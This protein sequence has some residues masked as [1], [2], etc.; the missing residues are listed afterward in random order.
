MAETLKDYL[1]GV[2]FETKGADQAN[3]AVS[4]LDG[5]IQQ[6]GT[7]LM[8]AAEAFRGLIGQM[9]GGKGTVEE[10]AKSMEKGSESAGQMKE[11]LREVNKQGKLSNLKQGKHNVHELELAMKKASG[12]IKK[13]AKMAVG[14]LVGSNILTAFKNVMEFNENLAKS[15]KELKK[16]VEQTRAYNLALQVM[17][18]TA[19]EIEKDKSLKATFENLQKIGNSLALPEAA[20]GIRNIGAVKDSLMELKMVGSYAIQWIYYKVQELAAGPL[21]ETRKLLGGMRDWLSGNIK[22]IAEGIGKAFGWVVQIINSVAIAIGKVLGWI[23]K[24]PPAI[25]IAGAAAIAVIMAVKS[26][27]ALITMII[28]A[29]LLLIDDFVT[30]MEGGESLF[31]DFWGACIEWIKKIQP[32]IDAVSGWI[33]GLLNNI[34]EI[35]SA[36]GESVGEFWQT[37]QDNGT[38]A[39][40]QHV[41]ENVFSIIQGLVDTAVRYFSDLFLGI[42]NGSGTSQTAFGFMVDAIAGVIDI[43]VTVIDWVTSF[44]ASLQE[45]PGFMETI[46]SLVDTAAAVVTA[47]WE[48]IDGIIQAIIAL[49]NGDLSGAWSAVSTAASGAWDLISST[50][51]Q[52]WTN[53]QTL[54][55]PVAEWFN[56][57]FSDVAGFAA[58]AWDNIQKAFADAGTW[59]TNNVVTPI[60]EAFSGIGEWFAKTFGEAW[61][62]VTDMFGQVGEWAAG[63]WNG[64]S[65]GI[66]KAAGWVQGAAK[67]AG[68][69][70]TQAGVDVGDFFKNGWYS[71]FGAPEQQEPITVEVDTTQVEEAQDSVDAFKAAIEN[72]VDNGKLDAW[73]TEQ[74]GHITEVVQTAATA[75][76]EAMQAIT[77][78]L[79]AIPEKTVIDTFARIRSSITKSMSASASAVAK[80][81]TSIKKSLN[82]IPKNI[83]I[84]IGASMTV[85]K[86]QS[87][88]TSLG[89]G[90][91]KTPAYSLAGM[92]SSVTNSSSSNTVNAPVTINVHGGDAKTT[93]KQVANDVSAVMRNLKAGIA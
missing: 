46:N 10:T 81:V 8:Q 77:E 50:A 56:G 6:L 75:V 67:D 24:L 29:I 53:L 35:F 64:I 39:R 20:A 19:K 32:A 58:T 82:S 73:Y 26:K 40:L 54:F 25:K 23:D 90:G 49:L 55:A 79:S 92:A 91:L 63:I 2:K 72:V 62:A 48:I 9:Q 30:Y 83:S 45:I 74:F 44:I 88:V 27:T 89:I 65:E 13:L 17:G 36:I 31:G 21:A 52:L 22:N 57:V 78:A 15:A 3:Q 28:T 1:V 14:Y 93:G 71:I 47:A 41:F 68:A 85:Q 69:W 42:D 11:A 12:T 5:I 34:W 16:T 51:S 18:K 60:K 4:E 86:Y 84:S 80:H 61:K 70:I 59:F 38:L 76:Q 33:E 87:A 66:A 43:I 7:V 37:L